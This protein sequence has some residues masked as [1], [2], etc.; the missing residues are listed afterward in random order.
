[1]LACTRR[2]YYRVSPRL[3]MVSARNAWVPRI[4]SA[5]DARRQVRRT[6]LALATLVPVLGL[7]NAT[8]I[9]LI[10]KPS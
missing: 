2:K 4:R 10:K 1:M 6:L 9:S 8:L 7:F 5:N 3:V